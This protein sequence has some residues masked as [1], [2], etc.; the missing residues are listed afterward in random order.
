MN[1]K[2]LYANGDSFIF[3]ME[4]I[5]EDPKGEENKEFA[6]PRHVANMLG[7]ETYI[8]NSYTGAPNEFI[9]RN[10]IFD[11]LELEKSGVNP[12]DVFVIVG[13]TSLFRLEIDGEAWYETLPYYLQK[14]KPEL[15]GTKAAPKEFTDSRSLF[16]NPNSGTYVLYK[17]KRYDTTYDVNPFCVKYLW[18]HDLQ[19]PQQEARI[20][21][22]DQ[23]LKSKGYRYLFVNTCGFFDLNIADK[24]KHFYMDL[25]E[26]FYAWALENYP[27]HRKQFN[28]FSP[29]PHEEYG[30]LLVEYITKNNL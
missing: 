12:T 13:W 15:I 22:L 19:N 17:G 26:T 20:I 7:C 27:T 23:F 14:N 4:C 10:T 25:K 18:N 2:Y 30:K 21:A 24:S 16:V 9:F 11:L 3:G 1:S 28:H 29:V 5:D 8:N 6:F